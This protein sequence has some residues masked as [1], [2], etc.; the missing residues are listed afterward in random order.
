MSFYSK[1]FN[2]KPFYTTIEMLLM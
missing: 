1:V 2:K